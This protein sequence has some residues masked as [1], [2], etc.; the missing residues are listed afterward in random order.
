VACEKRHNLPAMGLGLVREWMQNEIEE[1]KRHEHS[2]R[3]WGS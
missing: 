3:A 1:G 2:A